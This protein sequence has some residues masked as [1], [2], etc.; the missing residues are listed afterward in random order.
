[1]LQ[2]PHVLGIDDAPFRKTQAHEVPVVGVV[3]EGAAL[4]EGVALTS[5]PVDGAGA[6]AFFADWI[7]DLRWHA[8][9]QAVV[10][11]GITICGLGV[12]DLPELAVRTGVPAIA[13]TRKSPS[14]GELEGALEAAGLA[15][16]L[17]ILERCPPDRRLR[18]GLYVRSA[19]VD[20]EA[21]DALVRATLS[22]GLM[23]QP[24]RVAHLIGAALVTGSSRGKV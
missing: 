10:L 9:L 15:D 21:A 7:R 20:E 8:S 19:G 14:V 1:M 23:P 6:T 16:R 22:K 12:V 3:M 4:V 24:L 17:P 2:H 11:G 13:V 18:R 5:F